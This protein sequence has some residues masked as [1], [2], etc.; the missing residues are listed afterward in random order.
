MK[1]TFIVSALAALSSVSVSAFPFM[2]PSGNTEI[3]GLINQLK[4]FDPKQIEALTSQIK[5]GMAQAGVDVPKTNFGATNFKNLNEEAIYKAFGI[6][7]DRQTAVDGNQANA[8]NNTFDTT[9]TIPSNSSLIGRD[10]AS[11]LGFGPAED[12]DHPWI[13]PGPGDLRGPCPGLNTAAN[14]GYLPRNGVVNPVQLFVGAFHALA[15]SPDLCAVLAAISFLFKGDMTTL[16]LS[17]GTRNGLGDGLAGHGVLEGDAS[18]TRQDANLGNQW[19]V[20]KGRF[21]LFIKEM[22]QYGGGDV[23]PYSLAQSRYRA[24]QYSRKNNAR[25]DFN[26][27]RMVVAY[28]ESGFV[29][30]NLRGDNIHFTKDMAYHWFMLERFPPGWCKRKI[31][32]TVPEILAWAVLIEALKPTLPGW[33]LGIKGLFIPLPD[34]GSLG[35]FFGGGILGIGGGNTVKDVGCAVGGAVLGWFPSTLGNLF[36]ALNIGGLNGMSC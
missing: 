17:I 28:G 19:V 32:M 3:F 21:D 25:F 31:P 7:H 24:W 4:K 16:T 9:G 13:A 15:L 34:F 23:T 5:E 11:F 30:Q 22:D 10:I 18:V 12:A 8:Q 33:S 36:G 6:T 1:V 2:S 29:M 20:D 14:H 27:W 35:G 26:P